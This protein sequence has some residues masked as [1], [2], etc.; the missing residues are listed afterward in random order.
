MNEKIAAE[1][2]IYSLIGST[3]MTSV[4]CAIFLFPA[5]KLICRKYCRKGQNKVSMAPV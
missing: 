4:V 5:L 3:V 2:I 1:V